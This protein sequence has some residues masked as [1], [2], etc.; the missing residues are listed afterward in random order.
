MAS[1]SFCLGQRILLLFVDTEKKSL[2][3]FIGFEKCFVL[4]KIF[5]PRKRSVPYNYLIAFGLSNG[6]SIGLVITE[7]M[8]FLSRKVMIT[9]S[10]K[11]AKLNIEGKETV[12]NFEVFENVAVL[13]LFEKMSIDFGV[14]FLI[15]R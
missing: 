13:N 14:F 2:L 1:V 10:E 3:V 11:E 15:V 9:G 6:E 7:F 5:G 12:E 8:E 4:I